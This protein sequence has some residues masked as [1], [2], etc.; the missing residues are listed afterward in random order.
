LPRMEQF[1]GSPIASRENSR[2]SPA[3][4]GIKR[5]LS[6]VALD[7]AIRQQV[8]AGSPQSEQNSRKKVITSGWAKMYPSEEADNTRSE[9]AAQ[10]QEKRE[11]RASLSRLQTCSLIEQ[12][13]KKNSVEAYGFSWLFKKPAG[14]G[15]RCGVLQLVVESRPF[16]ILVYTLILLNSIQMGVQTDYTGPV[17]DE[18]YVAF[19]NL[20]AIVFVV[21]FI[22]K[23]SYQGHT[24]FLCSWNLLDFFITII[25]VLD[26]WVL[27]ATGG[28]QNLNMVAM[29]RNLRAVRVVRILRM[30]KNLRELW[31]VCVGLMKSM[32]TTFWAGVLMIF[33][34]YV[35]AIFV[36]NIF[37]EFGNSFPGFTTEIPED[38]SE[39]LLSFNPNVMFG[40]IT[41]SMFTLL[42]LALL[43]DDWNVV[44]R[45]VLEKEPWLL[46]F[47]IG[48]IVLVSL[49]LLNVIIGII[50]E[51]VIEQA[52]AVDGENEMLQR[53]DMLNRLE[54]LYDF[55]ETLDEDGSGTIDK[56]ELLRVWE[57]PEMTEIL[58]IVK[59]PV[60]ILAE[61]FAD[62]VCTGNSGEIPLSDF[63][64]NIVR[65]ITSDTHAQLL[66]LRGTQNRVN[67]SWLE[68]ETHNSALI[69]RVAR[70]EANI[71]G[72]RGDFA[73]HRKDINRIVLSSGAAPQVRLLTSSSVATEATG[74]WGSRAFSPPTRDAPSRASE[75]AGPYSF[76]C[77]SSAVALPAPP[78]K[79]VVS[80]SAPGVPTASLKAACV[81]PR[82]GTHRAQ[83]IAEAA[84]L[85][86][87]LLSEAARLSEEIANLAG[88]DEEVEQC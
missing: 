19:D 87:H 80:T 47:F 61:E 26:T 77:S 84:R 38:A 50:T 76:F 11:Q 66:D 3:E 86:S 85:M 78:S 65:L 72:L 29:L 48:F 7:H 59:M 8:T 35:G 57:R 44:G 64:R 18:I 25:S 45:A 1:H 12:G 69:E 62:L 17:L 68:L 74:C 71:N 83:K 14:I 30:L 16:L 34:I 41:R 20:V 22:F 28:S 82:G 15:G 56:D 60:G 81:E 54:Q 53:K 67:R 73:A 40:T 79:F 32:M 4:D 31:L 6:Y 10:D 58:S 55:I 37:A 52:K 2:G 63:V 24:Y 88:R 46:I 70:V 9:P 36:T 43:T 39:E 33:I 23:L 27:A 75:S 49:G 42:N 21:E 13:A 51:C 5:K